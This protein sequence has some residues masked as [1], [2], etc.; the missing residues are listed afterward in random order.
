[1]PVAVSPE[2]QQTEE[3]RRQAAVLFA[4]R[5]FKEA[6]NLLTQALQLLPGNAKLLA[7]RAAC[8]LELSQLDQALDDTA[9]AINADPKWSKSYFWRA[10]VLDNKGQG[11]AAV[12]CLVEGLQKAPGDP[13]LYQLHE[14]L[15][16]SLKT[17]TKSI[18]AHGFSWGRIESLRVPGSRDP[19][20]RFYELWGNGD[21]EGAVRCLQTATKMKNGS[22]P[23]ALYHLAHCYR[24]GAGIQQDE[25]KFFEILTDVR[26]RLVKGGSLYGYAQRALPTMLWELAI[27]HQNGTGTEKD[28]RKSMQMLKK[29]AELGMPEAQVHLARLLQSDGKV[30]DA[31]KWFETVMQNN[32]DSCAAAHLGEQRLLDGDSSGIELLDEGVH[33]GEPEAVVR[34]LEL[35]RRGLGSLEFC[36]LPQVDPTTSAAET[37][38]LIADPLVGRYGDLVKLGSKGMEEYAKALGTQ[39]RIPK[40]CVFSDL[41]QYFNKVPRI[42]IAYY[43]NRMAYEYGL[44]LSERQELLDAQLT[45]KRVARHLVSTKYGGNGTDCPHS[46]VKQ[47]LDFLQ[48]DL[49]PLL[50]CEE[51]ET[52][53]EVCR[54]AAYFEL[55]EGLVLQVQRNTMMLANLK[56]VVNEKEPTQVECASSYAYFQHRVVRRV[57]LDLFRQTRPLP[58]LVR[59]AISYLEQAESACTAAAKDAGVPDDCLGSYVINSVAAKCC[60]LQG[61]GAEA[62]RFCKAA[63]LLVTKP[64]FPLPPPDLFVSVMHLALLSTGLFGG[65]SPAV[66]NRED[67]NLATKVM[68][69]GE[70]SRLI[71]L[72]DKHPDLPFPRS[73]KALYMVTVALL[74]ETAGQPGVKHENAKQAGM[75]QFQRSN[76]NLDLCNRL[77]WFAQHRVCANCKTSPEPGSGKKLR[78]CGVCNQVSYCC[79]ECQTKHWT[80]HKKEC[81]KGFKYIPL[82]M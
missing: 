64:G 33:K 17:K 2:Q 66:F 71:K 72:A 32:K 19:L 12:D 24:Q 65:P 35:G 41:P 11:Q 47:T 22:Q 14:S 57:L 16:T 79:G 13:C 25:Q 21:L 6:C 77:E 53:C 49:A 27:A 62:A 5:N 50:A 43:A 10:R 69:G 61:R 3:L 55:Q 44:V 36:T 56:L 46:A 18:T 76:H 39:G 34:A 54:R 52:D 45:C 74:E 26:T 1:M 63:T 40:G 42:P 30:A 82:F 68:R 29:S 20:E 38:K 9:A 81:Q 31:R 4:K 48:I 37:F 80:K 60:L 15:V 75:L 67:L 51:T 59:D 23:I 28:Q 7:N 8:Y 78:R 73:A 70:V 58:K